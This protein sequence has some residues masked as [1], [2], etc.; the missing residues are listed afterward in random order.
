MACD[1]KICQYNTHLYTKFIRE[2]FTHSN[3]VTSFLY[4]NFNIG[5]YL[6]LHSESNEN[7][8][9]LLLLLLLLLFFFTSL[10]AIIADILFH[11]F[12]IPTSAPDTCRNLGVKPQ[13]YFV[14]KTTSIQSAFHLI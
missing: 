5:N 6:L 14:S 11:Q 12:L 4:T 13:L 1:L 2:M 3:S 7:I 8:A 9:V 10:S